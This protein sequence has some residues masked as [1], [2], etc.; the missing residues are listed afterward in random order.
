MKRRAVKHHVR[1]NPAKHVPGAK[2]ERS[3]IVGMTGVP[4]YSDRDVGFSRGL[5]GDILMDAFEAW[6]T[7]QTYAV[8]EDAEPIY[9]TTDICKFLAQIRTIVLRQSGVTD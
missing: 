1:P 8:D 9:Y 2:R 3:T 6:M 4:F 7:G 5:T